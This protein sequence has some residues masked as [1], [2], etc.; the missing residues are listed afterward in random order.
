MSFHH[1]LSHPKLSH[2]KLTHRAQSNPRLSQPRLSRRRLL[3]H[4]GAAA[5]AAPFCSL[6]NRPA[7]ASSDPNLRL[8]VLFSPN[9]T[10]HEHWRPGADMSV[11]AGSILEPL[12]AHASELL[13]LDELDFLL[14]DN[15][16]GGMADM[17]TA[18]ADTSFDQHVARA[19]GGSHRFESL[20]LGVQTS[21]W[22]G[23]AQTRM[24]YRDGVMVTPD[25]DPLNVWSRLFG[26]VDDPNLD[27]RRQSVLDT[28]MG[29]IG[30]LKTGLP[31]LEQAR[32]DDHLDALRD[33][34]RALFGA[35]SC[36]PTAAPAGF[37]P[38]NNDHFPDACAAQID[39]AITALACGSTPVASVQMSHTVSPL[40]MTW[41]GHTQG[42]H[43][44]S[45]AS[46]YDPASIHAF[47]ESEQW[48]ASQVARA[49]EGLASRTDPATGERLLDR[50]LV[51]WAKEL[52]DGRA[53]TCVGVPWVLAGGGLSTGRLVDLGGAT[54]DAVL[55]TLC[56]HLGLSDSQFGQGTAGPLGVLA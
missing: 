44:L 37:D 18:G 16:E 48:F 46:D 14:G 22:G 36:S 47:V 42:H 10:I 6:L 55:T 39:L 3:A 53:H 54:Q 19:L 23:S 51:L 1:T 26:E 49:I 2:P 31:T 4:A 52:G 25:D 50:T 32:L 15:H 7:R 8:L 9:G 40:T 38:D 56:N 21:A 34:E 41:L 11:P 12:S 29:D 24:S 5:V 35:S 27:L 20:T 33:V 30:R 17:L 13:V 45:H 28:L 43:T